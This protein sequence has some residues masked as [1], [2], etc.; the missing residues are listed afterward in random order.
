[1]RVLSNHIL[2]KFEDEKTKHMGT[3]QFKEK[4]DW[5]FEIVRADESHQLARWVIVQETGPDVPDEIK[6]GVRVLVDNLKWTTEVEINGETYART[7][8]DNLIGIDETTL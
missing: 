8:Y 2:F 3:S 1:M 6:P 5:G 7:D 4:T